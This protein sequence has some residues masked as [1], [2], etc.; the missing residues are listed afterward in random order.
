MVIVEYCRFGNLKDVLERH[1]KGLKSHGNDNNTLQMSKRMPIVSG[2]GQARSVTRSDMV[3]WSYQVAQGMQFLSSQYIVHG[4]LAARS[5]LLA[6]GN[7]VK[8]SDFG[9]A[10]AM[11]NVNVYIS[12]KEVKLLI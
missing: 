3:S 10:R 7:L 4:N 8:I 9:L 11:H 2:F 5:I 6:D 1:H 12:Q